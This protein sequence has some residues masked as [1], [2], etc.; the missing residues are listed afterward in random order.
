MNIYCSRTPDG[1]TSFNVPVMWRM[2]PSE[3]LD[4]RIRVRGSKLEFTNFL[5]L[6]T[7]L[8]FPIE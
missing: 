8:D 5:I 7:N 4:M 6:R 1:N 3:R 2:G